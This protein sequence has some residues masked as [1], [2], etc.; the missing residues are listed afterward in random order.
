MSR[1]NGR[2][3]DRENKSHAGARAGIAVDFHASVFLG[4]TTAHV[5]QSVAV[6]I[7]LRDPKA[8]PVI[9]YL[10]SD[11]GSLRFQ[12]QPNLGRPGV[13]DRIVKGLTNRE[14]DV[15]TDVGAQRDVGQGLR[16]F[17]PAADAGALEELVGEPADVLG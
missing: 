15:V 12:A 14:E 5:A 9:L 10:N 8:V 7:H 2:G 17:L 13:F 1:Y 4:Q 6:T 11:V 16:D 3:V